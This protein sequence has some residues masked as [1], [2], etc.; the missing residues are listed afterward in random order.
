MIGREP[1]F[2]ADVVIA[3]LPFTSLTVP[4]VTA[5]FLKV[6]VPAGVPLLEVTVAAKVTG[7]PYVDGFTD[8]VV[9]IVVDTPALRAPANLKTVPPPL[10]PPFVVVPYRLPEASWIRLA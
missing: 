3:A 1:A 10:A 8:E 6:T 2:N 5:P 4:R 9:V 7:C